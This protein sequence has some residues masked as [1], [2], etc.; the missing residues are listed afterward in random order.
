MSVERKRFSDGEAYPR[1]KIKKIVDEFYA[2][3]KNGGV[4]ANEAEKAAFILSY[5]QHLKDKHAKEGV[6]MT[7]RDIAA[8]G[9]NKLALE[10]GKLVSSHVNKR[11]GNDNEP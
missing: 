9:F 1:D 6:P 5:I 7:D 11:E 3:E 8:L 10:K 2:R 4:I